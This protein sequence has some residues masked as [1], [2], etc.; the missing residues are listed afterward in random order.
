[1]SK[2]SQGVPMN[3]IR[4]SPARNGRKAIGRARQEASWASKCGPVRVYF[5]PSVKK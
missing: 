5:D 3:V 2:G 4:C 1:M